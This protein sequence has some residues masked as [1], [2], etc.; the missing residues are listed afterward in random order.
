[1]KNIYKIIIIFCLLLLPLTN[2]AGSSVKYSAHISFIKGDVKIVQND[3]K[4]YDAVINLPV[5][6]GNR[7][8]L[9]SNGKCEIQFDNGSLFRLDN[10]SELYIKV[11]RA[12]SLTSKWDI[13]K[14]ELIKGK[15]YSMKAPYENELFE[16]IT[17]K[18]AIKLD[19]DRSVSLAEVDKNKETRIYTMENKVKVMYGKDILESKVEKVRSEEGYRV[20]KNYEFVPD[21]NYCREFMSW[22]EYINENFSRLH[23][24]KSKLPKEIHR[25]SS[26]IIDWAKKWSNMYGEWVYNDVLGL[27][28]KPYSENFTTFDKRP[29]WNAKFVEINNELFLVP[30]EKWGW[31]PATLGT[32]NW[33]KEQGWVWIPGDAFTPAILS[34]DN[35]FTAWNSFFM[36]GPYLQSSFGYWMNSFPTVPIPFWR[37]STGYWINGIYG[38]IDLYNIYR[39]YGQKQWSY[40]YEKKYGIEVDKPFIDSAPKYIKNLI[41]RINKHELS[42]VKKFIG[43]KQK[44]VDFSKSQHLK[45]Y[46][47]KKYNSKANMNN[48]DWNPDKKWA[49]HNKIKIEYS[50]KENQIKCPELNVSSKMMHSVR[51]RIILKKNSHKI[52]RLKKG[53]MGTNYSLINAMNAI[54]ATSSTG[55]VRISPNLKSYKSNSTKNSEENKSAQEEIK[56]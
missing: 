12:Q 3:G 2:L 5:V 14:I 54:R 49:K 29:F 23:Y 43:L 22:N 39:E 8:I 50:G 38:G 32:W 31:I 56:K 35:Y 51:N 19:D 24:G 13:T 33:N 18:A 53:T 27:V 44:P 16:I 36:F 17:P 11:I 30:V 47:V 55:V 37:N 28:W 15:I 1:M 42:E 26:G 34:I 7:I 25:Y 45:V 46:K 40:A 6:S 52:K 21:K 48:L 4:F 9:G 20:T 10:N 41:E